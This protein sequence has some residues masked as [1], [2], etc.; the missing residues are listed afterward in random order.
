MVG[1]QNIDWKSRKHF[2]VI[3]ARAMRRL[4]CSYARQHN[5]LKRSGSKVVL[6]VTTFYSFDDP[7]IQDSESED[8][9]EVAQFSEAEDHALLILSVDRALNLLE[10]RDPALSQMVELRFFYGMTI[11]ETAR[12]METSTATISRSWHVARGILHRM[13]KTAS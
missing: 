8:L 12:T 3:A 7:L 13:L 6:T 10:K 1:S 5:A 11:E 2:Y 4:L 9:E